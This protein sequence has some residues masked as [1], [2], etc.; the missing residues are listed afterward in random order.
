MFNYR[1]IVYVLFALQI[2][3]FAQ[4]QEITWANKLLEIT[5]RFQFENN[6]AEAI[7]GVPSVYPG[8]ID[9]TKVDTYSEGYIIYNENT[10]KKNSI[11]V[12]FPNATLARQVVV[13]GIFNVGSIYS[14][15]IFTEDNKEREIY[16][17]SAKAS[18]TKFNTFSAFFSPEKI[19]AIKI[20]I[21]P[22]KI[23]EWNIL[24]GIGLTNSDQPLD[25]K[26]NSLVTNDGFK[27]KEKIANQLNDDKDCFQFNPKVSPDGKTLY[28]VKECKNEANNQEIWFSEMNQNG[29]WGKAK[30]AASP[31][32]NKGHNFVASI[33]LDGR[34]LILGNTYNDDGTEAG[35]GVSISHM[36]D[37]GSWETPKPI[38]IPGFNNKNSNANFF[39]SPD[40]SVL[41]MAIQD[42]K[43]QG[44]LDLYFSKY[45]KFS[46][47][48]DAPVNLG[49]SINTP[50]A[51]DYP[52]L[53]VDGK[54]LYFSSKGY[55]G[56]GGHDIF[57]TKRMD[58]SY[59]KWSK[60]VNLGPLV[61]SK[62]DDKGFLIAAR[63]DQAFFN[64]VSFESDSL[65]HID[66]YKID[67]PKVLKQ[68][69]QVLMSGSIVDKA[70]NSPLRSTVRIKNK[71]GD[72]ISYCTSNPKNGKYILSVP[73]GQTYNL[74]VDAINYFK[75]DESLRLTDSLV[76]IEITKNF[77]MSAYLDSGQTIVIKNLLFDNNS[78]KLSSVTGSV[79]DSLAEKLSQQPDAIIEIG[80]HTDNVGDKKPAAQAKNTKGK[81]GVAAS[82][83]AKKPATSVAIADNKTLSLERAKSVGIYLEGKG[84]SSKRIF[85][86][87]YGSEQP[88]MPN[89]TPEG[90]AANR[91]VVIKFL[92]KIPKE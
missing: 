87:G 24:K 13:G 7:L 79:L 44:D 77:K 55:L 45:N 61:N 90:R 8:K 32:N 41:F 22:S 57:M 91:R 51:E 10:L 76:G 47:V 14:I 4:A 40:E 56:F 89:T 39:M 54:T 82:K 75:I 29:E 38:K 42:E 17:P 52:F 64:S 88:L 58:D 86:K 1:Y 48:W 71:A 11:K 78:A 46:Q 9:E 35:D 49:A 43:S 92:T 37:D 12:G 21:D 83:S 15:S 63:G 69:P 65:H 6:G 19:I 62:T 59:T 36:K 74:R 25:L 30:T 16:K 67:L 70:T 72:L 28:F 20:S 5:D 60:P 23:N 31:L 50:Y 2:S 33:S 3:S 81:K 66:I 27:S 53:A 34:F 80:G 68:N 84:I 18:K 26:P 73:F 85:C